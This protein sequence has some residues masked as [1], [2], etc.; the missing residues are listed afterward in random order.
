MI[1]INQII[2]KMN[3]LNGILKFKWKIYCL[4]CFYLLRLRFSLYAI[5]V[6]NELY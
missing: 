2:N 5:H 3:N 6:L 4:Q 1:R